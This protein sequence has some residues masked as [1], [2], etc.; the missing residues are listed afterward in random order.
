MNCQ[1]GDDLNIHLGF[2]LEVMRKI[3]IFGAQILITVA[4]VGVPCFFATASEP[5]HL[6]RQRVS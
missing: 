5:A 6:L 4:A 1:N 2:Q 3:T